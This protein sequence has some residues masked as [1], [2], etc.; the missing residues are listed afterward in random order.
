M[1]LA[2]ID[3]IGLAGAQRIRTNAPDQKRNE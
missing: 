3:Q 2:K 1:L